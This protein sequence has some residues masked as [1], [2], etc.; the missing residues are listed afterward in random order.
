MSALSFSSPQ[1][2]AIAYGSVYKG[3][4]NFSVPLLPGAVVKGSYPV[5]TLFPGA[6]VKG[7]YPVGTS[8]GS[9]VPYGIYGPDGLPMHRGRTPPPSPL[10]LQPSKRSQSLHRPCP[11]IFA[12]TS[13]NHSFARS[14]WPRRHEKLWQMRFLSSMQQPKCSGICARSQLLL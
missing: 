3:T 11:I 4:Y 14:W 5:G 10:N 1:P 2:K 8:L 9:V 12:I 7:S 6:V 13:T